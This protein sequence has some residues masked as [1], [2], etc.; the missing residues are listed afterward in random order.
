MPATTNL[1]LH[2]QYKSNRNKGENA[3]KATSVFSLSLRFGSYVVFSVKIIIL[4]IQS[5]SNFDFIAFISRRHIHRI[6]FN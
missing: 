1:E 3:R 5:P 2:I 4:L 6:K